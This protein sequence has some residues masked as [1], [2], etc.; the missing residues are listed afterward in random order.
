MA[1]S[2]QNHAHINSIRR[3]LI[4]SLLSLLTVVI[5]ILALLNYVQLA[6]QNANIFQIQLVNSAQ[7]LNAFSSVKSFTNVHQDDFNTISRNVF[8]I[9][10]RDQELKSSPQYLDFKDN[11]VFQIWDSNHN[12]LILKSPGAP[13]WPMSNISLGFTETMLDHGENWKAFTLT[14]MKNH[15][16]VIVGMKDT[17]KHSVNYRI[18]LHDLSVLIVMY[19]MIAT[20]LI[21]IIEVGLTPL[22]RVAK[23]VSQR[24]ASNLTPLKLESVPIEIMPLVAELNQ[25]LSRIEQTLLREKRF[26]AD[27]AHELRTPIAALKT[28]A[29]VAI[30]ARD[31]KEQKRI[32]NNIITGANRF[33]HVIE[34]LLT[35]SRLEP[36][37]ALPSVEIVNLNTLCETVMADLVPL[38]MDN[39][40]EIELHMPKQQ[41]I[42]EGNTPLLSVLLR[43]L[44][45]NA[46]RYTPKQG[47]VLVIGSKTTQGISIQVIDSGPGVSEDIRERIFDRFF[48]QLGNKVEGSGLGLSIVKRIVDLHHATIE[49]KEPD[50]GKG[51]EMHILFTILPKDKTR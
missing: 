46:I 21:I 39:D 5:A 31:A 45:D 1:H 11:L 9:L 22:K 19:F 10:S 13:D 43:N 32:L 29:E 4:V 42:V 30:K 27:A 34:Q 44:I 16:R 35:L 8:A 12:R 50:Q 15:R 38:A 47:K 20:V 7:L 49:A 36:E 48:R 23:E 24:D 2:K 28:Q 51:L 26:T 14:N 25:L 18:F 6:T 17:L 41:L 33:A 40:V 3:F 37:Q